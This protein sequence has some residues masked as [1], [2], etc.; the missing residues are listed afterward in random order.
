[1]TNELEALVKLKRRLRA[2]RILILGLTIMA[3]EGY[4]LDDII[5]GELDELDKVNEEKDKRTGLC[6]HGVAAKYCRACK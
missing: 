1:M 4:S 6:R 2:E 3:T 5:K